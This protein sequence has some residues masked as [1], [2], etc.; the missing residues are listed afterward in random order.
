MV[1]THTTKNGESALRALSVF[2]MVRKEK[3]VRTPPGTDALK[4]VM[5][6]G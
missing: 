6:L 3:H 5:P 1:E 2:G 4:I